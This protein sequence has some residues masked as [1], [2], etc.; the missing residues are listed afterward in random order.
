MNAFKKYGLL[1]QLLVGL[2]IC[3][4]ASGQEIKIV[5]NPVGPPDNLDESELRSV[6][7]AQQQWWDGDTKIAIVLLKS[8]VP[9]S[10][11]I[12]DKVFGMSPH[13][14]K[15]YWIQIVFRGKA[16]TPK[17]FDSEDALIAYIARTPGAI[18]VVSATA[19][20]EDLK[21]ILVEGKEEW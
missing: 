15:T 19:E 7:K 20:T 5:G 8:S 12:A 2:L 1:L 3:M 10:K 6:F 17:H 21:T 4:P 9:I 16:K 11:V 18:G 14:V 13:D